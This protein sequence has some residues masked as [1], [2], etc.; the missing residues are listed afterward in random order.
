VEDYLI[1]RPD[2]DGSYQDVG[3]DDPRG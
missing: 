1:Q 3:L 2:A